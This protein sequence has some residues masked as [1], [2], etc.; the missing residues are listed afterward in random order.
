MSDPSFA[1]LLPVLVTLVVALTA[2]NVLVGLFSGVLV[3]VAMVADVTPILFV[4]TLVKDFIVP[5]VADTYNASVLVLLVFIGGFVKLIEYSGGG[6]AFARTAARWVSGK[7]RAHV[8]AW[9]G[10]IMIFFSDLGTPLIVGPIFQPLMDRLRISRQKLAFILDST[11]SP[12]AILIPFIGWGVFIMSVIGDAFSANNIAISEWDA[13]VAAIPFQ[14]Y[15]W[16]A[17]TMVPALTILKFDYGA[18]AL[19]EQEAAEKQ[20]AL[21][22][23][24]TVVFKKD[25]AAKPILVW[26]PLLVLGATLFATL[27]YHGFP[28]QQVAGT[29]FRAALSAAYFLAAVVLVI[30]MV[31]MG[32]K[33]LFDTFNKYIEGMSGLM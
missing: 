11:S 1:S 23:V 4:P 10:G 33:E 31:R 6:T 28:Q 12:V 18:M 3:G 26:L 2:R 14:L 30:L 32:V 25:G 17:I 13:F 7:A 24:N 15:A 21:P 22:L 16:L 27:A 19:A 8:A 9:L 5:E 20:V 29:D